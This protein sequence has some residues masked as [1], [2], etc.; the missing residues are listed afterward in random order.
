MRNGA[1]LLVSLA[2]LILTLAACTRAEQPAPA[3]AVSTSANSGGGDIRKPAVAGQFY[4]AEKEK[5]SKMVDAMLARA[6]RV[7]EPD[8]IVIIA[9]HA[10]YVYS[11][12]VAAWAFKQVEGRD[13]DVVV[14]LGVNHHVAG[15]DKIS[16]YAGDGFETPLG[17]APIERDVAQALLDA[18]E[19]IVFDRE[20]HRPEHSIEVEIPF[21]QKVLP[22]VPIVPVIVGRPTPEN[23]R[24]LADALVEVLQGRKALIVASTD[25]SHYP[26]YEDARR[27]DRAT[28][29]A[30]ISLDPEAFRRTVDEWMGKGIPNLGTCACGQGPV[31]TAMMVARKLGA[32]R[33]TVIRY[34]NSCDT[35]FGDEQQVVGYGAVAFWH[36]DEP[37][38]EPDL[39]STEALELPPNGGPLE[40]S[41]AQK[42]FLL[43]VARESIETFLDYGF[44]PLYRVEDDTLRHLSGVF[45]TLKEHGAL[46]GC[47]GYVLPRRPLFIAT[48]WA[49]LAAAFNDPRFPPLSKDEL[50]SVHIEISV[51]SVPR[52]IEDPSQVQVGKHGLII[53][54]GRQSGLLLPQVPVEEGWD[55][56]EFL[57]GVCR[58]AGLPEDAWQD[59]DAELFVFTAAVFD[60]GG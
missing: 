11:G 2:T 14:V 17:V 39:P 16:V 28:L 49:A 59:P 54:K 44:A 33:A 31:L 42:E 35:P 58:K 43:Q 45:V 6:R 20:V 7:I 60:E 15:F 21:L 18:H 10:G 51:L 57:R 22:D 3:Q 5:L 1:L 56:E 38:P 13:Y 12:Q 25:L 47:I 8:P 48:E 55:R 36:G 4:P 29:E 53:V 24:I 40:L 32:N 9:P 50:E 26:A 27:V 30:I 46:R 52:R 37:A 23:C 19:D 34:A 41:Q